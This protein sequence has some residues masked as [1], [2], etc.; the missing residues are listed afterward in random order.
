MTRWHHLRSTALLLALA[1]AATPTQASATGANQHRHQESIQYSHTFH[2]SKSS[3]LIDLVV[4]DARRKEF[5]TDIGGEIILEVDVSSSRLDDESILILVERLVSTLRD[6]VKSRGNLK[7]GT[8]NMKLGLGMNRMSPVGASKLFEWFM[9]VRDQNTTMLA[10][11]SSAVLSNSNEVEKDDATTVEAGQIETINSLQS[12]TTASASVIPVKET[13]NITVEE[14]DLSFMNFSGHGLQLLNSVRKL[15]EGGR[16]QTQNGV[17]MRLIPRVIK[18]ENS[19]VGP[20]FC[21]SI[22]RGILN[23][24]ETDAFVNRPRSLHLGGNCAIGDAGTVALAAA[25]RLGTPPN[26]YTKD[27]LIDELDLS[28]CNVGDAGAEALA[29]ALAFN[30]YC[31]ALL[32]LSNNQVTDEGAKALGRALVEASRVKFSRGDESALVLKELVLD[33]NSA[34]GDE[35]AN[36][37]AKAVACGA[38]RSI[39]IRSCSVRAEGAAAFGKAIISLTSNKKHRGFV[40]IDLSGNQFGTIKPRKKK[41]AAYSATLIRDK[42]SSH[43]GFIGKSIQSRL[44]GAGVSMGITAESDDDE[45]NVMSGLIDSPEEAETENLIESSTRCGARSF[46][47]E[48]LND[49]DDERKGKLRKDVVFRYEETDDIISNV[50]IGMRQCCLDSGAIDALSAAIIGARKVLVDLSIDVSMNPDLDSAVEN[51]LL[52][53]NGAKLLS[54]LA[55]RHLNALELLQHSRKRAELAAAAAASRVHT[56]IGFGSA[57][58]DYDYDYDTC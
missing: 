14:V 10:T 23:S 4:S 1:T 51:A 38:I 30:P 25:L 34:L 35:G 50:R 33:N 17:M 5:S 13:V 21:R 32:D 27:A 37:L 54:K 43:I 48:I 41:G 15:F 8:I 12:N 36:A 44:K 56:E 57:F 58:D 47:G 24:A 29:L 53:V 26:K 20:A 28:S 7:N 22:G 2:H 19:G 3:T 55:D 16:I 6:D 11:I 9:G 52:G 42:A 46:A 49:G 31:L 45:E 39:S 40:S 18:M